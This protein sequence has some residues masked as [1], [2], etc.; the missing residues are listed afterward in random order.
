[1]SYLANTQTDIQTNK[2]WPKHYLLGGGKKKITMA[3]MVKIKQFF[4]RS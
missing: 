4:N 2:N 3:P 1:L